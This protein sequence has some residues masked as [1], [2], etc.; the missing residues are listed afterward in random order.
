MTAIGSQ[1]WFPGRDRTADIAGLGIGALFALA[2]GDDDGVILCPFRRCT[3]G[4]CPLCGTTRAALSLARL[5]VPT[6]WGR[7]PFTVL[8]VAQLAIWAGLSAVGRTVGP[9][10]RTRVL[11]ANVLLVL[12]VWVVRLSTSDIPTPTGLQLPF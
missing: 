8:V 5:D 1:R 10:F 11:S 3:G 6:A 7:H 9:S 12:V 4:Y 2:F